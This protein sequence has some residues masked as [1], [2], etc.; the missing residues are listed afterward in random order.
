MNQKG[1]ILYRGITPRSLGLDIHGGYGE[2]WTRDF[3]HAKCYAR[4]PESYVLEAVLHPSA[5]RLVLITEPDEDG[6]TN[7]IPENIQQVAQLI[8]DPW[9]Y[10]SLMCG[11]CSLW[12]V[13]RPKWTKRI[14]KA[15]YDS[16]FTSGFE[17]PEEYVLNPNLLQFTRYHRVLE[18][19]KTKAYPIESDTL[20][21]LEYVASWEQSY[22]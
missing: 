22:A 3:A 7:Y 18:N 17:G 20:K 15:G 19:G 16:L 4:A 11:R 13:W 21:Q 6:Y 8:K 1:I 10:D 14:K 9:L 2:T 12:D 5:K